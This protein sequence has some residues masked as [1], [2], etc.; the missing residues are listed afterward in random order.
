MDVCHF[1]E[2]P[3]LECR[4]FVPPVDRCDT[5]LPMRHILRRFAHH[6]AQFQRKID[7]MNPAGVRVPVS[8]SPCG[9]KRRHKFLSRANPFADC[10]Y[11]STTRKRPLF[12]LTLYQLHAI[13][14]AGNARYAF[15]HRLNSATQHHDYGASQK[16]SERSPDR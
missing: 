2:Q 12:F 1:C 16:S 8:D 4:C 6:P 5:P 3:I 9:G 13:F 11:D 10:G 15:T 7:A 14:M